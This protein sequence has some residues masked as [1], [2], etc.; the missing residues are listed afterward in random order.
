MRKLLLH[1][2]LFALLPAS[3][4]A[5]G[6]PRGGGMPAMMNPARFALEQREALVLTEEQVEKIE[7]IAADLEKKNAPILEE[8]RTAMQRG[9]ASLSDM[10]RDRLRIRR[11]QIQQNGRKAEGQLNKVLAKDQKKALDELRAQDRERRQQEMQE[12]QGGR[13]PGG[14]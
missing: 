11:D 14:T 1:L 6:G 10:E 5:Q 3:A 8:L 4:L 7:A 13:R 12:R 2:V 9:I